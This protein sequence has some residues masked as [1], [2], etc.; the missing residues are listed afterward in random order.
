MKVAIVNIDVIVTGD[1]R[2]PFAAA[3]TIITEDGKIAFVGD[4][5]ANLARDGIGVLA[6]VGISPSHLADD[7]KAGIPELPDDP[8][9][10]VHAELGVPRGGALF[11]HDP[12]MEVE[13]VA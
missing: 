10:V 2:E 13:E 4:E 9:V 11:L 12:A 1:W 3:N 6:R 7:G 8:G 5:P